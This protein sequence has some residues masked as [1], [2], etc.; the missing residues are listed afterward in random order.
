MVAQFPRYTG[1]LILPCV[2]RHVHI[3]SAC[4][5]LAL[6]YYPYLS[7]VRTGVCWGHLKEGDHLEDLGIDRSIIQNGSSIG[8]IGG[9]QWIDLA[10]NR[11][12]VGAVVNLRG[13]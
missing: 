9:I 11:A 12:F 7:M 1:C 5:L 3:A 13:P 10:Q 6:K 4:Y 2:Q 8:G